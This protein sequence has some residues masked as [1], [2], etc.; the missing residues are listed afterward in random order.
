MAPDGEKRESDEL[1]EPLFAGLR[2]AD[3][4][5]AEPELEAPADPWTHTARPP[6]AFAPVDPDAETGMVGLFV[7]AVVLVLAL[8]A[9][10]GLI[11]LVFGV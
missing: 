4:E 1:V 2:G 6:P 3:A 8:V 11:Y 7:K 10:G 5:R 9:F